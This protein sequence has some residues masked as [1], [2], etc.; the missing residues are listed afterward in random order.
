MVGGLLDRNKNMN[1]TLIQFVH[2]RVLVYVL[3]MYLG[4][5]FLDNLNMIVPQTTIKTQISTVAGT[6]IVAT[7]T[8]TTCVL[9]PITS[10]F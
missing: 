2:V 8:P 7:K 10:K 5:F 9:Y 6:G 1:D 3:R 4:F